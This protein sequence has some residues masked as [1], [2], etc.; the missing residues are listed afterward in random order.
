MLKTTQIIIAVL[1]A[2]IITSIAFAYF[3]LENGQSESISQIITINSMSGKIDH[4]DIAVSPSGKSVMVWHDKISKNY[5]IF[6]QSFD[7]D[8][9]SS[10]FPSIVN[11]CKIYD[12][13]KPNIAMDGDGNFVVVWQ[14]WE[15]DGNEGGIYGQRFL[16][17]GGRNGGEFKINTY[18][19]GNQGN[20]VVAMNNQ[21]NFIVVWEGKKNNYKN[22]YAQRFNA[23]GNKVGKEFGVNKTINKIQNNPSVSI[24]NNNNIVVVWQSQRNSNWDIY[25][26]KFG[27][28]EEIISIADIIVNGTT[29]FDQTSPV[30][31]IMGQNK[32]MVI[33][34]NISQHEILDNMLE[35][36][37]GQ[38]LTNAGQKSGN[39]IEITTPI[40]GHQE[41][42]DIVQV[43]YNELLIVWQNYEKLA[44]TPNWHIFGQSLTTSGIP[45]G[46][47]FMISTN[48]IE[49]KNWNQNPA[50]SSNGSGNIKTA[51]VNSDKEKNEIYLTK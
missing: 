40:F 47:L 20:P 32:F 7:E 41:N 13:K 22:I 50:I 2:S 42:P 44:Y 33:W 36:L 45:N 4:A 38:V 14:S 21:G 3:S 8:G 28:N 27:W 30:I 5:E 19:L 10:G 1:T 37:N 49:A 24:D 29:S 26:R 51:W 18:I 46:D 43:A 15:Q 12:K 31:T 6:S 39:E 35:N 23:D 48:G 16:A 11:H 34:E 17:N 9:N 25:S